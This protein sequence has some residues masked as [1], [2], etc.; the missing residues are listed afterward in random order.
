VVAAT[1]GLVAVIRSRPAPHAHTIGDP[2]NHTRASRDDFIQDTAD[3]GIG[4]DDA[5]FAFASRRRTATPGDATGP[6]PD[7]LAL[8]GLLL[9]RYLASPAPPP[10]PSEGLPH[11]RATTEDPGDDALELAARVV[12]DGDRTNMLAVLAGAAFMG[13][14]V[15]R[16]PR[17]HRA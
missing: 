4:R 13:W 1:C 3:G 10:L 11:L 5:A 17:D 8:V 6:A 16:P 2:T 9:G 7:L 15:A 14:L 12:S